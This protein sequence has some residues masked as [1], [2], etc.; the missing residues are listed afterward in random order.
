[1][2]GGSKCKP[3]TG[4]VDRDNIDVALGYTIYLLE[5]DETTGSSGST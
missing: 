2:L 4:F 5:T 1:M 3:F